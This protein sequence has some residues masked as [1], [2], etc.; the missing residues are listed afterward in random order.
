M[1]NKVEE[2]GVTDIAMEEGK[3]NVILL[4]VPDFREQ[5]S[6]CKWRKEKR[7]PC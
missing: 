5:M 4:N 6:D 1:G 3:M 2:K 7:E